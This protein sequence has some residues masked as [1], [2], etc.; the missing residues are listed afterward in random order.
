MFFSFPS[1]G[2]RTCA[3]T[4]AL[5]KVRAQNDRP[6]NLFGNTAQG[7]VLLSSCGYFVTMATILLF[8]G[9]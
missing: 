4:L 8:E 9:A 3:T 1:L 5:R 7:I 6:F 2:R